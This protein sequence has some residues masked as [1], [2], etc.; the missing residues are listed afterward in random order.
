MP[1][2]FYSLRQ[3]AWNDENLRPEEGKTKHYSCLL[4]QKI[5]P[6]LPQRRNHPYS[7]SKFLSEVRGGYNL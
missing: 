5:L 1:V 2:I 6:L 7:R 4:F 3:S